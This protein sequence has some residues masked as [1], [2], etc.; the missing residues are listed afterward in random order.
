MSTRSRY[1][2][3]F[4]PISFAVAMAMSQSTA[5]AGEFPLR[6]YTAHESVTVTFEGEG[7]FRVVDGKDTV[8]TGSYRVKGDQLELTDKDGPWACRK[9]G[10][11]TGTY[12]WKIEGGALTFSKVSDR[13]NARSGTLTPGTWQANSH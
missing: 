10:E 8:V 7:K 9:D 3:A 1:L 11:Q 12:K 2:D 6:S 13:C 4:A 5:F